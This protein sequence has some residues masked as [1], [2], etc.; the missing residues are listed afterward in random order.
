W[1]TP[2]RETSAKLR[3]IPAR[4]AA[5]GH[6][7]QSVRSIAGRRRAGS[8]Y[9]QTPETQLDP[10]IRGGWNGDRALGIPTRSRRGER[11][12]LLGVRNSAAALYYRPRA[13]TN[14]SL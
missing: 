11:H 14:A 4:I 1:G 6:Q 3:S 9:F 5:N 7:P 2:F 8:V 12:E 13:A 10:G